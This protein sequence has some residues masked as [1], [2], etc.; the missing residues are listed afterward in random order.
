MTYLKKGARYSFFH[1]Y[2]AETLLIHVEVLEECKP[3]AL[4]ARGRPYITAPG[5]YLRLTPMFNEQPL[6][7]IHP[8]NNPFKGSARLHAL[9][10][11]IYHQK[12]TTR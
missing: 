9:A 5:P 3:C 6:P 4:A 11:A 8:L 2:R 7:E 10:Q 12:R 1:D